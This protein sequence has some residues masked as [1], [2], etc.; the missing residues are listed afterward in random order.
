MKSVVMRTISFVI[1]VVLAAACSSVKITSDKDPG[2]DF[3]KFKTYSYYGWAENS[4]QMVNDLDKRR[5]ES[6]FGEEFSKRGLRYV[7]EGGDVIAVL[8]IITQQKVQTTATTT[9]TGMGM[10]YGGYGGYHG[11]GPGYG[12]GGG[13]NYSTTTYSDHEYTVGTLIIDLY[14][15]KGEQLIFEA[16]ASGTIEDN[17]KGRED[18][19][20]RVAA[21][22][23]AEYPVAPMQ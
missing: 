9:G 12:W 3:S 10:D 20:N 14:D 13:M 7:E 19:I 18:R 21:E 11:Y 22:I 8:F 4:D 23:M 16:S 2:V 17:P 6:A 1:L 15:S 5:I